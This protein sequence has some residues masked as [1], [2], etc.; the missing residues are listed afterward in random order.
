[1]SLFK[2]RV[3]S[4]TAEEMSFIEHLDVLRGHLFKS[5]VAVAIGAIVMAIYNKFIV[6]RILMGP[7]HSDFITYGLLCRLGQ[8]WGFGN[9]LC[10]QEIHVKM[11]SN[12]VSGQFDVYFNIILI[13]GFI[14]AF[15]Y[16]F[17]QFWKFTK[18]ALKPK[19][20]KNTRGVIFYVS[21]LFFLGVFFGYF[22]IAPYTINFFANFVLDSNIENIWTIASYFNT[23]VPLILGA[24]LAFQLPLVMY[25]LAKVGVVS[26]AYLRRVR[27]YAILIIVIVASI[28][29]PPDMLSTIVASVPLLI[30]YEISV[31]LCVRVEKR[32]KLEEAKWD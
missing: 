26:A 8:K 12:A 14:L 3:R 10:M 31:L 17:W 29:T 11:Q 5:A 32:E 22:V 7:T 24:G 23:I 13:G 21:L 4:G 30:L 15:P 18:P 25:F 20:L 16:V 19:E 6:Q 9:K 2:R 1:M 28:I 27:K